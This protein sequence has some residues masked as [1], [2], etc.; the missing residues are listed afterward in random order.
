[1]LLQEDFAPLRYGGVF[2]N[3]TKVQF[4][5]Q[6]GSAD[7]AHA[8]GSTSDEAP[9]NET[10]L[11]RKRRLNRNNER[12]KRAK[13]VLKIE[14]LTSQFHDLTSQNEALQTES[15]DL[16]QRIELV[17][18]YI[19][20]QQGKKPAAVDM[21]AATATTSTVAN[22]SSTRGGASGGGTERALEAQLL[23]AATLFAS[24]QQHGTS[25]TAGKHHAAAPVSVPTN[26][27]SMSTA[28]AASVAASLPAANPTPSAASSNQVDLSFIPREKR[29][30]LL[31]HELEKQNRILALIRLQV[32][33]HGGPSL[34]SNG[35]SE[36]AGLKDHSAALAPQSQRSSVAAAVSAPS[37]PHP[38]SP[39]TSLL[40]TL[41]GF[42]NNSNG[43]SVTRNDG[44]LSDMERFLLQR[45]LLASLQSIQNQNRPG[46]TS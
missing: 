12:K 45:Q 6:G 15:K 36:S 43:P 30:I 18:R 13:K 28:A 44:A 29:V 24:Q 31:Q 39:M 7:R 5:A 40:S 27:D 21:N 26:R 23:A 16:R 38:S 22:A 2:A 14:E 3:A 35:S 9:D 46:G 34:H 33:N 20:E 42:H 10:Q 4:L 17:K 25:C 32:G 19:N 1:M 8:S 41:N 37:Q 11:E